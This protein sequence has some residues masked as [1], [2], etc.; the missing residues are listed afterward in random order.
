[1]GK[2]ALRQHFRD[3]FTGVFFDLTK[4]PRFSSVIWLEALKTHPEEFSFN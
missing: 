2:Q 1:M 3:R 4:C